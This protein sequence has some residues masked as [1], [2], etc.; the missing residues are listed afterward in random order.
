MS[1]F[2]RL[3]H[4]SFNIKHHIAITDM[5]W[6]YNKIWLDE[7]QATNLR[8]DLEKEYKNADIKIFEFIEEGWSPGHWSV[9]VTFHDP[10]DEAEFILKESI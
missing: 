7:S 3:T 6:D 8:I 4:S 1:R 2:I 9:L 10:A 5:T